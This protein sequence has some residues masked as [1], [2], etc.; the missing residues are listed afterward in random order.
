[1]ALPLIPIAGA[2]LAALAVVRLLRVS[3]RPVRVDQRGE[4]ALD[5]LDE[6]LGLGR[7]RAREQANASGRYRRTIRFGDGDG[8]EIDAG[9]LARIRVRRLRGGA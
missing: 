8:V 9:W 7:S 3:L 4:D 1:M 2:S 5:D 6:G